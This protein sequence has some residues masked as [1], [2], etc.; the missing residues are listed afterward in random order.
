[1]TALSASFGSPFVEQVA[2]LRLRLANPLATQAWDDLRHAEH[3]RAFVIAGAMKADLLAD[4]GAAVDRAVIEHRSFDKF[5]DEFLATADKHNW[6]GWTG[7]TTEKGRAWRARVIYRTNMATSYAAGRMAQLTA[8]N[9]KFWVYRHGNAIE[10]RLQH[11]A[12]DGLAL[13]P[14]HPFWETHAPPN[15]WGCTCRIRGTNS[16]AGIR[17]LNGDPNKKLPDGWKAPDPKTGAPQGI[18]KGWDYAPGASVAQLITKMVPKLE[19]LPQR[20]A[21]DLMKSWAESERFATWLA[22]PTG[23]WPL[24]KIS[25]EDALAIGAK[26]RI[27][28]LTKWTLTKQLKEHGELQA[29]EYLAAQNVVDN[30]TLRLTDIDPKSGAASRLF[31]MDL[32]TEAAGGYVLVVKATL[33]GDGLFVTSLRRLSRVQFRRDGEIQRLLKER[34]RPRKSDEI[35]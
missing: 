3:D 13:A 2:A 33:T 5:K 6:R 17:R 31:V 35:K 23:V 4:I 21:T 16:E 14:D 34:Q 1:M 18:D 12:W 27:A 30:A 15:G 29:A 8:G 22:D 20:L 28:S 32:P 10:P 25:D 24:V 19:A 26:G 7:D 9:F 11:L